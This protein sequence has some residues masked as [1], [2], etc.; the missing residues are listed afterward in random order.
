MDHPNLYGGDEAI[1]G[2]NSKLE[3]TGPGSVMAPILKPGDSR[4]T[5]KADHPLRWLFWSAPD[6][7]L[8]PVPVPGS[9][10]VKSHNKSA[11]SL[12]MT[13]WKKVTI[14]CLP[15]RFWI[16]IKVPRAGGT[17][18]EEAVLMD[19]QGPTEELS[20]GF[21]FV[22][23]PSKDVMRLELKRCQTERIDPLL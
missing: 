11:D 5:H 6:W 3:E 22:T 16:H 14:N 2:F 1:L 4:V 19:L 7:R 20:V 9:W 21:S 17:D 18:A 15:D 23:H 8:S 13:S 10:L 12:P